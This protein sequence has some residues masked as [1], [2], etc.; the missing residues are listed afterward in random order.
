M[1]ANPQIIQENSDYQLPFALSEDEISYLEGI[2]F[3][4]S[5]QRKNIEI[6]Y[7]NRSEKPRIRIGPY[8]GII[9]INGF[10][11]L[12]FS[13]K[14]KTSLFYMLS[15]LRNEDEFYYDPERLIEIREGSN[16]FD[17]IAKFYLNHLNEIVKRGLLKKNVRKRERLR[18]LR[19]KILIREQL[20]S[21]LVDKTRLT[22]EYFDLTYDNLENRIVMSA[23]NALI[24]MIQYNANLRRD[25]RSLETLLKEHV[26]I[27][28]INPQECN[29]VKFNR[30][31]EYYRG[32]IG[33][34]RIIL[35]ERFI[36]SVLKG[37]SKG[38][39]FIV[40]MNQVYEDF[41]SQ[42]IEEVVETVYGGEGFKVEKQSRFTNL[43]DRMLLFVIARMVFR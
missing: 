10:K 3:N 31:N 37:S 19:G 34:S 36:R 12:H 1:S 42:M 2:C 39:N 15:Y 7:R 14:V 17:I 27:V 4:P 30:L 16:F 13:T 22:C 35:E 18:Y 21:N 23:L 29:L 32:I 11:R 33:L 25:L 40:N 24:P 9:D 41:I 38:F 43:V 6:F 20:R 8:A 5:E 28:S 26:P